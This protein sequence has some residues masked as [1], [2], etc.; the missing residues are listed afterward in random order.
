MFNTFADVFNTDENNTNKIN[1]TNPFD[2]PSSTTDPFGISSN[3]KISESSEKFDDNPFNINANNNNNNN[4]KSVRPRSG[5]EALSS[6]NWLA[7]QH[8]MD[9]ANLDPTE[10]LQASSLITQPNNVN[11]PFAISTTT[12]NTNQLNE[13]TSQ[14]FPTD[15]LFDT[16][17]ESSISSINPFVNP[18]ENSSPYDLFGF[19]QANAS[20][21]ST[22]K[23]VEND[24]K[25]DVPKINQ[26]TTSSLSMTTKSPI[27][28]IASSHTTPTSDILDAPATTSNSAPDNQFLDWLTQSDNFISDVNPKINESSKKNDTNTN[29]NT[30]DHFGSIFRQA[31]TLSTLSMHDR[32][33]F[34]LIIIFISEENSQESALSPPIIV[35]KQPV[36]RS[37]KEDVPSI[38]IHEPTIEHNDSNIVPKGYFDQKKNNQSDDDSDEDTKMVFK[39]GERKQNISTDTNIPVPLL[40][41]P[42]S[43]SS[44]RNYKGASDHASS[45]SSETD[46]QDDDDP[47]AMFRS[48]SIKNKTN[49]QQQGKNLITDWD[50]DETKLNDIGQESVCLIFVYMYLLLSCICNKSIRGW[51]CFYIRNIYFIFDLFN[52][53]KEKFNHHRHIHQI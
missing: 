46:N 31:Q 41:P 14:N 40:P 17:N 8:S 16:N 15:L 53:S 10:D 4:N 38:C 6:S 28:E 29:K 7:Y 45:S 37:S 33:F 49:Q 27:T 52:F 43:P 50:E 2:L 25:T 44:S 30:D 26:T 24:S 48:K 18:D 47:L 32:F 12:S 39:I 5:K 22:A 21:T 3:M 13:L 36:R 20:L 11:N 23:D 19:N 1:G 51:C 9:E 34:L 42:P 35:S